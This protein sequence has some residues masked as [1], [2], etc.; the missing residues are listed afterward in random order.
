MKNGFPLP[1]SCYLVALIVLLA[2]CASSPPVRYYTL[3]PAGSQGGARS[4]AQEARPVSVS[5]VPVEIPDYLD[6]AE[7]VTQ[8]GEHELKLAEYDRWAGSLSD[9]ISAV[10]AENIATFLGSDRVFVSPGIRGEKN[11]FAVVMRILRLDCVPGDRVS[12]KAQWSILPGQDKKDVA[13]RTLT[14]SESVGDKRYE[15]LVAAFSRTLEQVSRE[16]AR[17]IAAR[18]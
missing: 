3:T 18:K 5:I 2:G 15:T 13:T 9:N 6:R 4:V 8:E 16:I 12:L 14:F 11:D 10:L 1:R 17:E 7:I